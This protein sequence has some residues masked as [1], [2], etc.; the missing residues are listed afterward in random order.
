MGNEAK[1]RAAARYRELHRTEVV[2]VDVHTGEVLGSVTRVVKVQSKNPQDFAF[3]FRSGLDLL[4]G[5]S[6]VAVKVFLW[7]TVGAQ[8]GKGV[9]Y[10]D[11]T[12]RKLLLYKLEC[13]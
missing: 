3:L 13:S 1:G 2:D 6:G 8:M 11:S 4:V 5:L 9:V 7:C 12:E 10:L